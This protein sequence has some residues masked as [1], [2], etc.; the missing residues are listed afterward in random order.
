MVQI[1]SLVALQIST[2][3]TSQLGAKPNYMKKL[4]TIVKLKMEGLDV[5]ITMKFTLS[6]LWNLTD[7]SPTTCDMFLSE[8]G[9][10]VF[11]DVLTVSIPNIQ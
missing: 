2:D 10:E 1:S 6:A 9:L 11:I 4:L 5:D 7:E 3:Q 8:G